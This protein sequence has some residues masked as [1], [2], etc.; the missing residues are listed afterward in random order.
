MTIKKYDGTYRYV[1]ASLTA[2]KFA[3][4]GLYVKYGNTGVNSIEVKDRRSGHL[5]LKTPDRELLFVSNTYQQ[6]PFYPSQ[7]TFDEFLNLSPFWENH[8]GDFGLDF[9]MTNYTD[10]IGKARSLDNREKHGNNDIAII[11]DSGGFQLFTGQMKFIDPLDV[12]RWYNKNVD[13]GLVLDI[14]PS[15]ADHH[16]LMKVAQIQKRNTAIMMDNKVEGVELMNIFHGLDYDEKNQFREVVERD[17]IRR[18]ALGGT[19]FKNVMSS[20]ADLL[21]I[22]TT[23]RKYDQ[24]HLLGVTNPVQLFALMRIA[25]NKLAPLV[26]SDSNTYYRQAINKGYLRVDTVL[27]NIAYENIGLKTKKPNIHN[28]LPCACPVCSRVRYFDIF[29]ILNGLV[30]D[31]A[32]AFHNFYKFNQYLMAMEDYCHK[33][34]NELKEV[35]EG[36]FGKR[37]KNLIDEGIKTLKFVD[38]VKEVGFRAAAKEYRYYIGG[39]LNYLK[40]VNLVDIGNANLYSDERAPE[41]P[42]GI[43]V[44]QIVAMYDGQEKKKTKIGKGKALVRI[45]PTQHRKKGTKKKKSKIKKEVKQEWKK[46]I[47]SLIPARSR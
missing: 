37:A 33:S 5:W 46:G 28:M 17:D 36:Q 21:Q 44:E 32:L 14:P 26:T 29:S 8:S 34:I 6:A 25:A 39:T 7:G 41:Q 9:L 23:G 42:A 24:Y 38:L 3:G 19:Y 10:H 30:I 43:T 18:I 2:F 12:I 16:L 4:M 40:N 11:S 45:G 22:I 47:H 35:F 13:I 31:S 1:P 15:T 27:S 20:V